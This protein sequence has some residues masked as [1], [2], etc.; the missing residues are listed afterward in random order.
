[1]RVLSGGLLTARVPEPRVA[2]VKYLFTYCDN[3]G[4]GRRY[5]DAAGQASA[6]SEL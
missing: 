4:G 6:I 5:A 2:L 3:E 1:M